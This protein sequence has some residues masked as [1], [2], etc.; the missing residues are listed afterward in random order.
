MILE[1][2]KKCS[3]SGGITEASLSLFDDNKVICLKCDKEIVGISDF[4]KDA[5][6]SNKDVIKQKSSVAFIFKC[7]SCNKIVE[8]DVV[9]GTPVGKYCETKNCS[10]NLSQ[11]MVNAMEK[12]KQVPMN[13]E[14]INTIVEDK[15]ST[16]KK[17]SGSQKQQPSSGG[18]SETYENQIIQIMLELSENKSIL[19]GYKKLYP[20]KF[21]D[22]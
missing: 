8:T 14:K 21:S 20:S 17:A 2:N 12:I 1:C 5:M 7:H 3:L 15:T 10:I 19:D 22:K 16:Q 6:R 13:D 11:I 9:N 18:S 4:T